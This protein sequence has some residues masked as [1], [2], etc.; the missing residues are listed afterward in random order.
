[1]HLLHTFAFAV[2]MMKIYNEGKTCLESNPHLHELELTKTALRATN[3]KQMLL[4]GGSGKKVLI[5]SKLSNYMRPSIDIDIIM[6]SADA[7]ASFKNIYKDKMVDR[8]KAVPTEGRIGYDIV[9]YY[10][11]FSVNRDLRYPD[12]DIFTTDTG[13]GPIQFGQQLF[14]NAIE[15][16][17]PETGIIVKVADIAF[18]IA[19]SIN[20]LV[21][22]NMRARGSFVALFSNLDSFDISGVAER[23]AEY[24]ASSIER[25]N[26]AVS[27]AYE[28]SRHSHIGSDKNYREYESMLNSKIPNRISM[29]EKKLSKITRNIGLSGTEVGAGLK[30][31]TSSL[32]DVKRM[33]RH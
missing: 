19:T 23:T 28:N 2:S 5:P 17:L 27:A 30:E 1:M 10:S 31:F 32:K 14:S 20:P 26:A 7:S 21:Y 11:P 6:P 3:G 25:V 24:L 9:T 22:T 16:T 29:M 33:L 4:D 18:T 13:V 15:V 12:T 8:V